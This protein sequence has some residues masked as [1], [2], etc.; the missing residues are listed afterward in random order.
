MCIHI[1]YCYL[2][3]KLFIS[4]Y[5]KRIDG[6]YILSQKSSVGRAEGLW[7]KVT[8]S[9]PQCATV[10][11]PATLLVFIRLYITKNQIHVEHTG[12]ILDS[13]KYINRLGPALLRHYSFMKVILMLPI[14]ALNQSSTHLSRPDCSKMAFWT[15]VNDVFVLRHIHVPQT[16]PSDTL[17]TM[18]QLCIQI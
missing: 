1:I 17:L 14:Q 13:S 2:Y 18:P 11:L 5:S 10:F 4:Q 9:I 16:T 3:L 8:G 12:L 15:P 7:P 6:I